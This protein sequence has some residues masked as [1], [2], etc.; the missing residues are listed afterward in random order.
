MKSVPSPTSTGSRR[1]ELRLSIQGPGK[2]GRAKNSLRNGPIRGAGVKKT[3]T[4]L[5]LPPQV[6]LVL[7]RYSSLTLGLPRL[8]SRVPPK[9]QQGPTLGAGVKNTTRSWRGQKR[10]IQALG[11]YSSKALRLPRRVVLKA[12]SPLWGSMVVWWNEEAESTQALAIGGCE[13]PGLV[14]WT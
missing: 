11:W 3:S 4:Y 2:G 8:T 7:G 10:L 1:G 5:R 12:A 14:S 13:C 6:I 9:G